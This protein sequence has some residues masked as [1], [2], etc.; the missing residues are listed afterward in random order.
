MQDVRFSTRGRLAAV[1]VAAGAVLRPWGALAQ[2]AT[3]TVMGEAIKSLTREEFRAELNE[4][5]GY[6]EAVTPGGT[7]IASA[8]SDIQ[9]VQPFLAEEAASLG[10]VGLIYE[11]LTGGDPR[12]GQP[13]PGGLADWWEIAED[14]RTYTFHLNQN[15]TWHDGTPFTA[16]D[17]QFSADALA[18]PDAGSVYTGSFVDTVESWRV[19]DDYTFEMVAKEPVY[20]FLYDIQTLFVIPKHI[21]EDVPL[22]DWRT[23]PGATGTDPS[24]V[25][26]TGPFKFQE[27]KQGES[28]TL[29]RNDDY[30]DKVPYI[31]SYMLRIWPDQTSVVNAL[32]NGELDVAGLEPSDIA[33]VE[34]APGINVAH[35][36]T[37]GFTYYEFNLDE[38]VTTKWQ[39]ERVRQALLYALDRES[40]VNDILLGY[41]EVAQGTQPVV[42]YAYAPDEI[43]T[44]Y[45]Y[46][47]EKAR[48]L[49]EEAGWTDSDGDGIVDKDGEA[50]SFEFLYP[51]GSP[52]S[53][54]MAAY[55]QDAWKAIGV[56]GSPRSLEFPALIEATTTDPTFEIA[57]YGFSWD[58]SFI[59]DIMF[60]CDQ[61]QV[62]FNDMK[63]CN[64]ELDEIN[65]LAKRTFDEAARRDLLIE[66]SNIVNDEQPV[67][68]LHFSQDHAAFNDALQNYA[69]STWGVD[70]TR[71]WIQQ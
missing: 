5:M 54:Q 30:Y 17:V 7:F 9:T 1:L 12:T 13:A 70:L 67:A 48:A 37:R 57:M 27:W 3:P 19:I 44:R 29:V 58:A 55:I 45:T 21:W 24:R 15:V 25:V 6:T 59:Q 36:P 2:D 32:L 69:P 35:Y 60:G 52:T 40:I 64:P 39:D 43:T 22:T 26:G 47:P 51:A 23:D 10:V 56:A 11:G 66:A 46:D 65:D 68:V 61:Y 50:L 28:V 4:A 53:D 41:A 18:N 49:L 71:V 63:Y 8:T 62:G 20:T 33:A 38:T 16:A 31:D 14:G 42:S 34:G